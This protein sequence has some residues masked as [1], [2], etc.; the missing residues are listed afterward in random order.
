MFVNSKKF[1]FT[2]IADIANSIHKL[3]KLLIKVMILSGILNKLFIIQKIK[4]KIKNQGIE[5][6]FSFSFLDKSNKNK[7]KKGRMLTLI[8]LTKVAIIP[9]CSLTEYPA[10]IT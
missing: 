6:N 10:P 1:V 7:I 4:N 3:E 9:V 2:P 8:I 5:K